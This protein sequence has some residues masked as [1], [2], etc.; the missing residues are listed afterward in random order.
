MRN[1]LWPQEP[2]C[3]HLCSR[4]AGQEADEDTIHLSPSSQL[5]LNVSHEKPEV[6][7]N[8]RGEDGKAGGEGSRVSVRFDFNFD[9]SLKALE[10]AQQVKPRGHSKVVL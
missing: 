6:S 8:R 1:V 3:W 5:L 10:A 7:V 9:V 2:G 4:A